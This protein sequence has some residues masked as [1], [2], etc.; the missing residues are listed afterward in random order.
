MPRLPQSRKS[1]EH[2][3]EFGRDEPYELPFFPWHY[4]DEHLYS[5]VARYTRLAR[6]S[7]HRARTEL[8]GFPRYSMSL[9]APTSIGDF[10]SAVGS[11]ELSKPRFVTNNLTPFKY[12]TAYMFE[13]EQETAFKAMI[14]PRGQGRAP[15]PNRGLVL[16]R[17]DGP[18]YCPSCLQDD[19]DDQRIGE[20]Y[21]RRTHQLPSVIV[22]TKHR[23]P[24][25]RT[26]FA[27]SHGPTNF[28]VPPANLADTDCAATNQLPA[29]DTAISMLCEIAAKSESLL[30]GLEKVN[31]STAAIEGYNAAFRRLGLTRGSR[32]D[33]AALAVS[34]KD[35]MEPVLPSFSFLLASDGYPS[36]WMQ[37]FLSGGRLLRNHPLLHL[38]VE[39]WLTRASPLLAGDDRK[40]KLR[41]ARSESKCRGSVAGWRT[42]DHDALAAA[43]V[44]E[45]AQRIKA[46]VP[47][48]RVTRAKLARELGISTLAKTS[49]AAVSWPLAS[50]AIAAAEETND[51]YFRRRLAR[52]IEMVVNEGKEPRV[53]LLLK[54]LGRR[55][56]NEDIAEA[57]AAWRARSATSD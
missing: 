20:A 10:C 5:L 49:Q 15:R 48:T 24:L 40:A 27:A 16:P 18:R 52:E 31:P 43:Q 12:M 51:V 37:E 9:A 7:S 55:D 34:F 23:V 17:T 8:F 38:L 35:V 56:R 11:G 2:R 33:Y 32:V 45:A 19:L 47:L 39:Q 30:N 25:L 57:I 46:K 54:R 41:L 3:G 4:V 50:Q 14:S 13:E 44:L 1:P 36:W 22:C 26:G 28:V 6:S 29:E 53:H 21:W 42:G